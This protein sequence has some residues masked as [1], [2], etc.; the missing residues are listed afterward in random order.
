ALLLLAA[1]AHAQ[2]A[3]IVGER[4]GWLVEASTIPLGETGEIRYCVASRPKDPPPRLGFMATRATVGLLIDLGPP[5]LEAGGA[6]AVEVAVDDAGG[7]RRPAR[8]VTPTIL[9]MM[10]AGT[11][12]AA[13]LA[14]YARGRTVAVRVPARNPEARRVPLAGSS[15]AIQTLGECRADHV[16]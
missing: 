7:A 13:M 16:E 15:W 3:R 11:D 12:V 5:E 8:P 10:E 4:G 1:H 2:E 6:Y 9:G 14:P